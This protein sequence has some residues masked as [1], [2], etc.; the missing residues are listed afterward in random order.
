MNE[1][2]LEKRLDLWR[3][4]ESASPEKNKKTNVTSIRLSDS[5][6]ELLLNT[7]GSVQ[8]AIDALLNEI[9]K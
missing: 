5:D 7:F 8:R 9:K 1:T 4:I 3:V 2:K 6:K